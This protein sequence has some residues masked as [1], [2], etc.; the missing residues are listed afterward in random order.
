MYGNDRSHQNPQFIVCLT[1]YISSICLRYQIY[2]KNSMNIWPSMHS[3]CTIFFSKRIYL[4]YLYIFGHTYTTIRNH[5]CGPVNYCSNSISKRLMIVFEDSHFTS[6]SSQ[7]WQSRKS[8]KTIAHS[9]NDGWHRRRELD[10]SL[11]K[12]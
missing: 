5:F 8:T 1:L 4:D 11:V 3:I 12:W 10:L 2:E 6:V 7:F 9:E